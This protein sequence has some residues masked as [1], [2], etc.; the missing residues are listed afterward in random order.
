MTKAGFIPP[1]FRA[2]MGTPSSVTPVRHSS[3]PSQ[4][5]KDGRGMP[6]RLAR[7]LERRRHSSRRS[8]RRYIEDLA[9]IDVHWLAREDRRL[10]REGEFKSVW[11]DRRRDFRGIPRVVWNWVRAE[12]TTVDGRKQTI[13]FSQQALHGKVGRGRVTRQLFVCGCGARCFRL[14]DISN[15]FRCYKCTLDC[16]T[17]YAS[18]MRSAKGRQTLK[19]G[20]LRT[21]LAEHPGSNEIRRP[22]GMWRKTYRRLCH[23]LQEMEA[24]APRSRHSQFLS[25]RRVLRPSQQYRVRGSYFDNSV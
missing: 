24:T 5:R 4:L 3:A 25:N 10:N 22:K 6:I 23:Q 12:V 8:Q 2:L 11:H 19:A 13:P 7:G 1:M 21:F 15:S 17:R 14:Y 9:L 18:Q 20:K 16:G